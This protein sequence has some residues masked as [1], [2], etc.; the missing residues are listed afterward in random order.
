MR[1]ENNKLVF[2]LHNTDNKIVYGV[3]S[4]RLTDLKKLVYDLKLVVSAHGNRSNGAIHINSLEL[5]EL[6]EE[7]VHY[8]DVD[9]ACFYATQL[10]QA[11]ARLSVKLA[12]DSDSTMLNCCTTEHE[13]TVDSDKIQTDPFNIRCIVI[14]DENDNKDIYLENL[15]LTMT[16]NDLKYKVNI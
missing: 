16:I 12:V 14:K 3:E 11:K 1:I 6:F 13:S 5:C 7:A 10:A 8:G 15:S 2:H 9:K 4:R